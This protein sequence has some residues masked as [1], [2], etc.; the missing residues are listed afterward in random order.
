MIFFPADV[1]TS[2]LLATSFALMNHYRPKNVPNQLL[3]KKRVKQCSENITDR[4]TTWLITRLGAG[5]SLNKRNIH[6]LFLT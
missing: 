1:K 5:V 6:N 3:D 2:L 4:I